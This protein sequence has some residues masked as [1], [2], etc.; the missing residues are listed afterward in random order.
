MEYCCTSWAPKPFYSPWPP[1][2]WWPSFPAPGGPMTRP[3]GVGG[4]GAMGNHIRLSHALAASLVAGATAAA[5]IGPL[6]L[7]AVSGGSR[8]P[9]QP[10]ECLITELEPTATKVAP[11]ATVAHRPGRSAL[12]ARCVVGGRLFATEGGR[13]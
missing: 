7:F 11:L 8:L 2:P 3:G 10:A 13:P 9:M 4:T 1:H 5:I 12:V 6:T